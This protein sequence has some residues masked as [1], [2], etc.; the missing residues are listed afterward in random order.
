MADAETKA[1][2]EHIRDIGERTE[3]K[4]DAHIS[5]DEM[6]NKEFVLPL[7][8]NY[9]QQKGIGRI[10]TALWV[11]LGGGITAAVEYWAQS[12]GHHP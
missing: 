12:G 2:L 4:L 10:V 7:W 3:Q 8:N 5:R 9:Q 1:L 6:I 11:L